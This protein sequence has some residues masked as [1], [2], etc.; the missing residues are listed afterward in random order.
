M[1]TDL[2]T[3]T[4]VEIDTVLAEN[5]GQQLQCW[6]RIASAAKHVDYLRR[7]K[8]TT[9]FDP[10][11]KALAQEQA[12]RDQL[13]ALIAESLPYVNEYHRR[14]WNRYYLVTNGNGHVHRG[15]NCTTCFSTTQYAWLID[16]ADCDENAMIEEWG[17]RACTVC[18]PSAP[19]NPFYNRPARVDREAKEA[20]AAEKA[21]KDAAKAAKLLNGVL[22]L[23][24]RYDPSLVGKSYDDRI[25]TIAAAKQAIRDDI[26]FPFW[27]NRVSPE[28]LTARIE[29]AEAAL[30]ATGRVTQD[31]IDTIKVRALKKAQKEYSR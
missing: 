14:P 21:A 19:T 11:D 26:A 2:T 23:P 30:L 27:S 29:L 22:R 16:L 15:T 10:I 3:Q 1:S 25:E 17:E 9:S 12:L 7:S 4:P 8:H 24:D 28:A 6:S 5:Y 31:E 20:K 18:F 13:S